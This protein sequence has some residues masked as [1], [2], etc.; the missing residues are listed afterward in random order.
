IQIVLNVRSNIFAGAV[1]APANLQAIAFGVAAYTLVF[2]ASQ[3]LTAEGQS[4]W[5]LFCVPQSL[6]SILRQK[7]QLWAA[8]ATAYPL[9]IFAIAIGIAGHVSLELAGCVA[10]VVVGVPIFAAIATAL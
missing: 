5:V 4:L 10:M 7:A 2:S 3:T 1:D 8:V 6:E 9:V